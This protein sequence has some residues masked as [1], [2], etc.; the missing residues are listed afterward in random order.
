MYAG[1]YPDFL[2]FDQLLDHIVGAAEQ[3][4]R[5]GEAERL[6]GLEID[7]EFDFCKQLD[8]QVGGLLP[9]ENAPGIYAY[10]VLSFGKTRTVSE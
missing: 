1:S 9:V 2:M 5:E 8:R 3:R 4:Q 7:N 10:N 6:G